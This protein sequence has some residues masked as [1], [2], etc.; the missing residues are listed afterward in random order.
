MTIIAILKICAAIN[1]STLNLFMLS[2]LL[3]PGGED[4]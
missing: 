1:L 4:E 2:G 3:N